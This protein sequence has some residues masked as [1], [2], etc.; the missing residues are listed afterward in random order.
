MYKLGEFLGGCILFVVCLLA[1][2]GAQQIFLPDKVKESDNLSTTLKAHPHARTF[3]ALDKAFIT[4]R[5]GG[6]IGVTQLMKWDQDL[7]AT[8]PVTCIELKEGG[9]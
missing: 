2:F 6:E 5:E 8:R 7:K 9:Y 1:A 3:C 4:Y